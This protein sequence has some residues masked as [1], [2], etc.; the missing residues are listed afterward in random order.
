MELVV[1]WLRSR[2]VSP[3]QGFAALK[4]LGFVFFFLKGIFILFLN[5]LY[6][7]LQSR[8]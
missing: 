5:F 6:V 4:Y 2:P 3:V 1:V 7:K 8:F